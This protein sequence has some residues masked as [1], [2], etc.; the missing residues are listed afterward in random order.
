[1]F[2]SVITHLFVTNSFVGLINDIDHFVARVI[3]KH[4][5]GC[6]YWISST[7][8]NVFVYSFSFRH[9]HIS[10]EGIDHNSYFIKGLG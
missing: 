8:L 1:V 4:I 5:L 9:S 2:Y 6:V 7:V 10:F 3:W